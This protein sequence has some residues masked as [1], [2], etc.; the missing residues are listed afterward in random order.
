MT[1]PDPRLRRN[2]SLLFA[3]IVLLT[4]VVGIVALFRG[5]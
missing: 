4:V 5:A 1:T 3:G 2:V